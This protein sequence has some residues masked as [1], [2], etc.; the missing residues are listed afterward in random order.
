MAKK[1][2]SDRAQTIGWTTAEKWW[3]PIG[4]TAYVSIA[5]ASIWLGP[6]FLVSRTNGADTLTGV[7]RQTAVASARQSV[8]LAAGGGLALITLIV[9]VS[10]DAIAR[11]RAQQERNEKVSTQFTEAITQLADGSHLPIRLG[12]IY[13]LERIATD[14]ATHRLGALA[15]L[16]QYIRE[17]GRAPE[18][19]DEDRSVRPDVKTAAEV[20]ARLTATAPSPQALSLDEANLFGVD[21]RRANL[22]S[23]SLASFEA[24]EANLSEAL[25]VD[26][27]TGNIR[28]SGANLT[29]ANLS[30]GDFFSGS[31]NNATLFRVN[32]EEAEFKYGQMHGA[33]L[34]FAKLK[35]ADFTRATLTEAN[36]HQADLT[37]AVLAGADLSGAQLRT[38]HG[39]TRHQAVQ[40]R[41]WTADTTWPPHLDMPDTSDN[42]HRTRFGEPQPPT[43]F[44]GLNG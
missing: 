12:G 19:A 17:H 31:F 24:L 27:R 11:G 18:N 43:N 26:V 36:F 33:V 9:T 25:L 7:E 21:L 13:A 35:G 29:K 41:K 1:S 20:V 2:K 30:R 37:S 8:L 10:R 34:S 40:A 3:W 39:L 22:S 38:A 15:V 28:L 16:T 4:I 32:A 23:W 14:S 44:G 5:I 6:D 42:H